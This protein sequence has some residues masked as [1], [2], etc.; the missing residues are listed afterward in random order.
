MVHT[1]TKVH[2]HN[3]SRL[4]L[5]YHCLF[6]VEHLFTES[7]VI[8]ITNEDGNVIAWALRMILLITFSSK[9]NAL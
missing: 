4:R 2:Y 8:Q 1:P 5:E 7:L 6:S 3:N 9:L